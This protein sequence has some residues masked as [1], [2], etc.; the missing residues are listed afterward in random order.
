MTPADVH[1]PL[2]PVER[3]F[4]I[5]GQI[6]PFNVIARVHLAGRLPDG[7]L[8]VAAGHLAAEH[9]LLQTAIRAEPDGS[10]PAFIRSSRHIPIRRVRGDGAAWERFVDEHELRTAIDWQSG[11]LLRIAEIICEGTPDSRDLVLTASHVIADGTTALTLLQRLIEHAAA[12]STCLEPRPDI[13]APE[14]RLPAQY[15]GARGIARLAVTGAIETVAALVCRPCRLAPES[16]VHPVQRRTRLVRRTLTSTQ[17][18]RLICRCRREGVT[19]HGALAAAMAMVIGPVA[20]GAASGRMC[21]GSPV[22]FRSELHPPVSAHE[23]GSYVNTM[24][25][26]VRFGQDRDLWSMARQ[27]NRSLGRRQRFGQH[28]NLLWAMRFICPASE[29]KSSGMF[30]LI[31]RNGP[32]NVGISN[33]GRYHFATQI[34]DWRL[35]GAQF[36]SGVSPTGYFLATVNTSH[37]QLYW[38]FTYTEGIV[39]ER[40]ARHFADGCIRAVLNV[41]E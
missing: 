11:P 20:A 22:D 29:P 3:W 18:Q 40:S 15:R 36:I 27:I 9:P 41:I 17:V 7:V 30:G 8:R 26:M 14:D 5:G 25:S 34:G 37:D 4:W 32:L 23:A 33:V 31:E 1:R 21:I 39:S 6:A 24:A 12:G 10:D 16:T 35:S 2:S 13:G 28:L 19:V 38:N